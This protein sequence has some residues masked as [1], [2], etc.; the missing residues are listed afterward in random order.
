MASKFMAALADAACGG[1]VSRL[2]E[3][4]WVRVGAGVPLRGAPLWELGVGGLCRPAMDE[5]PPSDRV[6]LRL[7]APRGRYRGSPASP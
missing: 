5:K 6:P 7:P 1:A 4:L 2:P 3:I